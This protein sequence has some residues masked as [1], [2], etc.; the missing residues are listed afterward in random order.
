[1]KLNSTLSMRMRA[2]WPYLVVFALLTAMMAAVYV[3]LTSPYP[4]PYDSADYIYAGRLGFWANYVDKGALPLWEFIARGLELK[5]DP[6]KRAEMSRQ[7]RANDDPQLYRHYHGPLYF[8]FLRAVELSGVRS[9]SGFR[10]AG[11][12]IHALTAL[13]VMLAFWSMFPQWHKGAG[14]LAGALYLFNRTALVT[15]GEITQHIAFLFTTVLTLWMMS[16]FCRRLELRYWYATMGGLALAFS[17]VE[18]ASLLAM[19]L[20]LVLIA[21]YRPIAAKWPSWRTRTGYLLRGVGVFV[22][23]LFVVWPAGIFKLALLRGFVYLVYIAVSRKTFSPIGPLDTWVARFTGAP[24]EHWSLLAGFTLAVLLWRRLE[25]RREALPWLLFAGVF[26]VITAKVTVEYVHYRGSIALVWT[27]ATAIVVAHLWKRWGTKGGVALA[28][29]LAVC[30]AAQT[31]ERREEL[32]LERAA[33]TPSAHVVQ[34]AGQT[35]IPP[36]KTLYLPYYFV[37]VLHLYYPHI[38]TAGYDIDW[39]LSRLTTE[40]RSPDAFRLFL[41]IEPVCEQ[42]ERA[43][44]GSA[45]T[46]TLVAPWHDGHRLYAIV[47]Q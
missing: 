34:W 31:V 2:S 13:L 25:H 47:T 37:P 8:Y 44:G 45:N 18:T 46:R 42:V 30:A 23:T 12:A 38:Q 29:V 28:A 39:P 40:I 41:C 16:L 32:K 1:M 11:L 17:A 6:A 36:G 35:A 22:L 19:T 4:Y 3:P 14:L 21:L 9:E 26:I 33:P 24:W 15:A 20:A 10:I 43:T 5:D 7:A 27:M